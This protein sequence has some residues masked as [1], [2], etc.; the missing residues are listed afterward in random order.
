MHTKIVI[1]EKS[2][3]GE[4]LPIDEREWNANMVQL[5]DHANYLLVNDI[6]YEMLEGRLNVNTGEFELLVVAAQKP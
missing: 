5:L 1:F 3:S 2:A 6:E 4:L